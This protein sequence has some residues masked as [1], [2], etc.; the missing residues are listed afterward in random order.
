M[1]T[2]SVL[3]ESDETEN[4]VGALLYKLDKNLDDKEINGDINES[5]ISKSHQKSDENQTRYHINVGKDAGLTT[6]QF[7]KYL[8]TKV[9]I[10]DKDINDVIVTS[11][12]SFFTVSKDHHH[13]VL[14]SL[15][16]VKLSGK[17]VSVRIAKP[18]KRKSRKH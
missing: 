8:K 2:A 6:K 10:S 12:G 17:M 13:K 5:F 15:T 7:V 11:K 14:S 9:K 3:L 18:I 4:I 16:N 1:E